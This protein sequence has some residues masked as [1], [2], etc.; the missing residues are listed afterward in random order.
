M[1]AIGIWRETMIIPCGAEADDPL[2]ESKA[3]IL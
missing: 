1:M 3:S 2:T